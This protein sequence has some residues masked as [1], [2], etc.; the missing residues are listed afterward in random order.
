MKISIS[1]VAIAVTTLVSCGSNKSKP[2]N[3]PAVQQSETK[4]P[5][6]QVKEVASGPGAVVANYLDLKNELANDKSDGA[7][8]VGG[9]LLRAIKELGGETMTAGQKKVYHDLSGDIEE[10]ADHISKN[11]GNIKHQR[12][13]F[14][15][16]SQDMLA[17]VKAFGTPQTLYKDYCPM[18]KAYWLS[19]A[20]EIDNPYFG[21]EM[22]DCGEIQDTLHVAK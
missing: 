3:S 14:E 13:H 12:E 22:S 18:K 11:G 9:K 4:A 19:E 1:I 21:H 7:A 6:V 5:S 20:P 17:F 15:N 10:N 2:D 8:T 16:L